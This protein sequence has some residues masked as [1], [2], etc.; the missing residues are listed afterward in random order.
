VGAVDTH[1]HSAPDVVARSLDDVQVALAARDAGMRAIVLKSHHTATG[2]R[3]QLAGAVV[4]GFEVF[5]GVALDEAVGGL[6]PAAVEASAR[7]GG[8]VVWLPTTTSSTFLRWIGRNVVDHPFGRAQRGVRV[9]AE[10]GSALPE[11]LDVLE[12]VAEHG[13]ILATGHLDAREISVVV[14]EAR[15]R[16]IERIVVTHPEHPYVS[17]PHAAQRELAAAGVLFERCYLAFPEQRGI[18]EPVA[19]A[20]AAVGAESTILATDF[21]QAS[22]PPPAEG[23][24]AFLAELLELGVP[25]A[26]LRRAA[27]DNPARLL[28]LT[29]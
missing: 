24:A 23:Y 22:N 13:L 11:L 26:D 5:G 27:A 2:D 16:G 7:L 12:A 4:D 21:G 17:L 15:R 9:L 18:A 8:V 28:G 6:N 1:V 10:D 20:M 19:E 29:A 25:E 14:S 3:A